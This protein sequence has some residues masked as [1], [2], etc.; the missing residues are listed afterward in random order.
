MKKILLTDDDS[1]ILRLYRALL[2]RKY[3]GIIIH[4]AHDGQEALKQIENVDYDLVLSDINMPVMDGLE[5]YRELSG[6]QFEL[7]GR[8]AFISSLCSEHQ[9]F[10]DSEGLAC[11]NKPFQIDQFYRFVDAVLSE[12]EKGCDPQQ[13]SRRFERIQTS[14]RCLLEIIGHNLGTTSLIGG[15]LTDISDGGIGLQYERDELPVGIEARV[16]IESLNIRERN[17][18]MVWASSASSQEFRGGMQWV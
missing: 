11:L 15:R 9:E 7:P 2:E 6:S 16:F 1:G 5:F 18:K 17:A 4:E 8:F 10:I 3:E 14:A 13:I 12:A